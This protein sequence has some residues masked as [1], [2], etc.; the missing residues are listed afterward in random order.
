MRSVGDRDA[1]D[2]VMFELMVSQSV[3][4]REFR[5]AAAPN[6]P[7]AAVCLVN[8]TFKEVFGVLRLECSLPV[9]LFNK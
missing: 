9:A 5:P 8:S 1:L 4:P 3:G 2:L 6:G 7:A